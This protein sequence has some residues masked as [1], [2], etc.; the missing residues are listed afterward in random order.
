MKYKVRSLVLAAVTAV[1]LVATTAACTSGDA[2]PTQEPALTAPLL[3]VGSLLEPTSWDPAQANEGNVQPFYQAVYDTLLKNGA[4]GQLEPMLATAWETSDDLLTFTMTLR[5]DVTFSDGVPFNA[6][7]V[8]ANFEHFMTANGPLGSVLKAVESIDTP[9]ETTVVLHLSEPNPALATWL[10]SA[11]G[12]M[13][14]PDSL[15]TDAIVTEPVGSGPYML[16]TENTVVGSKIVFVR[17]EGYWGDP[18]PY[19]SIEFFI[20]GDETA[21]LNALKSGEVDAAAFQR[22]ATALDA[23]SAGFNHDPFGTVF[24]GI[25]FLDREGK[26]LPELADPDVRRALA[27]AIDRDALLETVQLGVGKASSQTYGPEALAYIPEF[28]DAYKY[29]PE[30]ARALLAKSG[31]AN[32]ELTLPI[33][34]AYDPAIYDAIIQN[35]AD[36]GVTVNRFDWG[37]GEAI[38]STL[39]AEY[40]IIYFN[41]ARRLDWQQV[42]FLIGP[43]ATWNPFKAEDPE[44]DGYIHDL[45]YATSV[46][47]QKKASQ[48]IN[49]FLIDN[50]WF[51]PLYQLEQHFYFND[52]VELTQPPVRAVP[53]IYDYKPTGR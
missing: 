27:L 4:D 26:L 22:A 46:D 50:T 20:I 34:P 17:N 51:A 1:A 25:F 7:A 35:W 28:D 49:T 40:P 32:L 36:I 43:N 23:A 30:A 37:P 44:L 13:G 39:R 3:R 12:F 52:S 18:L 8:K 42:V 10:A 15:G 19:D 38:P 48:A 6:D 14:S 29:D 5:D 24:E 33:N 21:R 47:E 16:D 31:H 11:P 2:T 9:D 45:Q 53:F 41:L